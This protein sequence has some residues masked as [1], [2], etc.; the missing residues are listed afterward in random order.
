MTGLPEY[1]YLQRERPYREV[2]SVWS[3]SYRCEAQESEVVGS[4]AGK[5]SNTFRLCKD[6]L[7]ADK[8][9][10]PYSVQRKGSKCDLRDIAS[11][12]DATNL[13][14]RS[15][16]RSLSLSIAATAAVLRLL[17]R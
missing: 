8:I 1:K 15:R 10:K 7:A 11:C 4:E 16:S 9:I 14:S 6:M 12:L 17:V 2:V 13:R 5:C 3:G